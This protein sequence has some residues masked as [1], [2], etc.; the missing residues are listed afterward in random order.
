[1]PI[2]R[3]LVFAGE[4]IPPTAWPR[5]WP[6]LD[7][8]NPA[9]LDPAGCSN[10]S[11]SSIRLGYPP[12]GQGRSSGHPRG[13]RTIEPRSGIAMV[14]MVGG[15]LPRPA[16][17]ARTRLR[18]LAG[19]SKVAPPGILEGGVR[20]RGGRHR[21][22]RCCSR[23]EAARH[24][25]TPRQRGSGRGRA[26]PDGPNEPRLGRLVLPQGRQTLGPRPLMRGPWP[27]AAP[28]GRPPN[29]TPGGARLSRSTEEFLAR[30]GRSTG[31]WSEL[32]NWQEEYPIDKVEGYLHALAVA[33][34]GGPRPMAPGRSRLAGD[35]RRHQ[36][37]FSLRRPP[38]R[39]LPASARRSRATPTGPEPAISRS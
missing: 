16:R 6:I 18:V 7:K 14:R 28:G 9:K 17:R 26:G 31:R 23:T 5:T 32:R 21:A 8:Y 34:L 12:G 15:L 11:A 29:R 24:S 4:A 13:T 30:Q 27:S 33:L 36:P 37:R 2:H 19:G 39:S 22:Q 3:A 10:W 25:W 38:R 20:D 1:M 35:L